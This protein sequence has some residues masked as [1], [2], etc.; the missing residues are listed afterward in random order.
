[1]PREVTR[2]VSHAVRNML[3]GRAAGRCEFAG[4]NKP[5]WKSSVT[6]DQVNI[7]QR[8]HIWSFSE[9]G[10]RGHE[11]I[12]AA[13]LNSIDNLMLVCHESHEENGQ[14]KGR[15]AVHREATSGVEGRPRGA[16]CARMSE[17][18]PPPAITEEGET[19]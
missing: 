3:W 16:L 5:L 18:V 12:A 2:S 6:Q 17:T 1:M 4:C 19:G 9:D 14:G 8:A 15:W 13:E 11:G 7:A 10:P